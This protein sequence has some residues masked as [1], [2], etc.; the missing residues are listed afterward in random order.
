[1]RIAAPPVDGAANEELILT[2]AR[3]LRVKR[4]AVAIT[5]GKTSKT[6]QVRIAGLLK[7]ELQI[8]ADKLAPEAKYERSILAE[9][10]RAHCFSFAFV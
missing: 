8:V 2:L 6:K 4:S 10:F 5:G 1:V 9:L 3:A 7:S